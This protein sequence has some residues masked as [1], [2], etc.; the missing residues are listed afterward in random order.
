MPKKNDNYVPPKTKRQ[1]ILEQK[2]QLYKEL[3]VLN[4]QLEMLKKMHCFG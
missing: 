2:K 3:E 1:K 4:D